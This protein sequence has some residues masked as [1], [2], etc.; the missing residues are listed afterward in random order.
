MNGCPYSRPLFNSAVSFPAS[1]FRTAPLRTSGPI[2]RRA[3]MKPSEG[4]CVDQEPRGRF[5]HLVHLIQVRQVLVVTQRF[6]PE[7]SDTLPAGLD[8]LAERMHVC[9]S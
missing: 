8:L 1:S 2:F 4:V 3:M 6:A 9:C 7:L 5:T